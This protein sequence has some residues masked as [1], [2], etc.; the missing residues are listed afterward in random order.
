MMLPLH[1]PC[2]ERW[3]EG[4]VMAVLVGDSFVGGGPVLVVDA[5]PCPNPLCGD[6][7]I[8]VTKVLGRE[9]RTKSAIC[10]SC[11]GLGAVPAKGCI[12][13]QEQR[14]GWAT[15]EGGLFLEDV[16][17]LVVPLGAED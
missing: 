6:G 2:A 3:G 16:P 5:E 12:V 11:H 15:R 13:H 9:K 10:P 8:T 14:E 17:V 1:G 7:Q 4:P